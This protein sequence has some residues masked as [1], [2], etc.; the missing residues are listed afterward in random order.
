MPTQFN[1]VPSSRPLTAAPL[2]VPLAGGVLTVR[3]VVSAGVPV[4]ECCSQTVTGDRFNLAPETWRSFLPD[5]IDLVIEP[6]APSPALTVRVTATSGRALLTTEG[7][8]T[9]LVATARL[10]ARLLFASDT[11]MSFKIALDGHG[12]VEID[13]FDLTSHIRPPPPKLPPDP[14]SP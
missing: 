2:T 8:A 7:V 1:L 6:L 3:Y 4:F 14:P 10:G 9:P 13:L 5:G 11:G 12:A